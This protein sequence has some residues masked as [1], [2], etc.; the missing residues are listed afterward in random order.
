MAKTT[1]D[2]MNLKKEERTN[3]VK[4]LCER[5]YPIIGGILFLVFIYVFNL[6][7][8]IISSEKI[9]DSTITFTSIIVGFVGAL[10]GIL[11]SIRDSDIIN[12]LFKKNKREILKKYFQWTIISGLLLVLISTILY[13]HNNICKTYTFLNLNIKMIDIIFALWAYLVGYFVLS[14]YRITDIM[15]YIIFKDPN[16]KN[17]EPDSV[18]LEDTKKDD[19]KK[20]HT[21]K[22]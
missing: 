8:V 2:F 22:M 4:G 1:P 20:K 3:V 21:K 15:M 5:I 11:F 6:V 13:L 9:L 19:L 7:N 17:K 10:I 12:E 18:K 16:L 14:T